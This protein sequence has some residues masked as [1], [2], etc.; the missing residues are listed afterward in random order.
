[1]DEIKTVTISEK[2][3]KRRIRT[4]KESLSGRV[5]EMDLM[6]IEDLCTIISL[7]IDKKIIIEEE[8]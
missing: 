4:I 5:T 7:F 3:I 1:M 8:T 2:D 6:L